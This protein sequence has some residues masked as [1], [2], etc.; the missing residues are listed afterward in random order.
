MSKQLG[1]LPLEWIRAFESAGRNGSF[2]AAANECGVTQAAISQR[3][4]HL[5]ERLGAS[6]FTRRARGVSLTAHGEAWLPYVSA[7]LQDLQQSAEDMFASA[8]RQVSIVAS[9][10]V[11][12]NWL[13]PRLTRLS[14]KISLSF[15][16]MVVHADYER[17]DMQ[18]DVRYGTGNWQGRRA[19]KLFEE[20]IGPVCAPSLLQ[21]G[22]DWRNLPRISVAGPRQGWQE[23]VRQTGDPATPV[24]YLR[25]DTFTSALA[26]AR[27]GAGVALAS[28]PLCEADVQ[29]GTLLPLGDH[30]LEPH[31]SYWMTSA[32]EALPRRYW[33]ELVA[34]FCKG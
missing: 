13:A 26:A 6:L 11:T 2:S 18:V 9:G 16:T 24:P 33:D 1:T 29:N 19:E 3:I 27:M 28:L 25:F 15:V 21:K 34:G 12:Q 30:V 10:S 8:G 7:A 5:E 4:G 22:D 20:R 32:P 23:W 31:E 14:P 17:R